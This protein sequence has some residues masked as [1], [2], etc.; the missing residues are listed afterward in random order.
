MA[1]D[2]FSR[3]CNKTDASRVPMYV[4]VQDSSTGAELKLSEEDRLA[5]VK[6]G[7]KVKTAGTLILAGLIIVAIAEIVGHRNMSFKG[8]GFFHHYKNGRGVK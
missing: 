1:Y 5:L 3:R 4:I 8:D 2:L 7:E 6:T